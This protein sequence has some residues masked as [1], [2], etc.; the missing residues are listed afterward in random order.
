MPDII[1]TAEAKS[2]L[3]PLLRIF[4]NQVKAEWQIVRDATDVL[5]ERDLHYCPCLD[6]AIGPFNIDGY[7]DNNKIRIQ[8]EYR[9]NQHIFE[10]LQSIDRRIIQN[11]NPRCLVAIELERST[12]P[13][14]RMGSIINASAMGKVGV[15]IGLGPSAHRSLIRIREFLGILKGIGKIDYSPDNVIITE[16]SQIEQVLSEHTP[17]HLSSVR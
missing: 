15:V 7:V 14:H 16:F 17:R 1:T 12:G 5:S 11:D 2:R 6:Y 13:K 10:R 3:E 9:N 4:S 8:E